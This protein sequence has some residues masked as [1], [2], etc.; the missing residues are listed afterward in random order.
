MDASP[1]VDKE[2]LSHGRRGILKKKLQVFQ[3][4][5]QRGWHKVAMP[6]PSHC[7]DRGRG[8]A[9]ELVSGWWSILDFINKS[10]IEL[11]TY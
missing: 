10:N 11:E 7:W 9:E 2:D 3:R 8:L 1:G 5:H 4:E 6:P